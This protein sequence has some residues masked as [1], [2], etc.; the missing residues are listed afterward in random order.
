MLC[1]APT[2]LW[3]GLE[4]AIMLSKPI[5]GM[6]LGAQGG[7]RWYRISTRRVSQ[8]RLLVD[9]TSRA[10][11]VRRAGASPSG[12]SMRPSGSCRIPSP[13]VQSL[14]QRQGKDAATAGSNKQ[15]PASGGRGQ[16]RSWASRSSS[17]FTSL[18]HFSTGLSC[19][20]HCPTCPDQMCLHRG[21]KLLRLRS[22]SRLPPPGL[23]RSSCRSLLT[24]T[25]HL[26]PTTRAARSITWS[27]RIWHHRVRSSSSGSP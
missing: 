23:P 12:R 11:G 15:G 4:P 27:A 17:G 21:S 22:A 3:R 13:G 6:G 7:S 10:S 1:N 24:L 19:P 2:H 18:P 5:S 16:Q 9:G 20:L 26:W 14:H 25:N 8:A